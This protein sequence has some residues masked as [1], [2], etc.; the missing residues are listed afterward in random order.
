MLCAALALGC[1]DDRASPARAAPRELTLLHTSDIH[2]RVWPF[3]ARIS[4]LEAA[5]GLG[6]AGSV[7][8][9]GGFARLATLLEQERASGA[10]VWLDSGDALE[11]APVF[12]RFGG[13]PELE[14]L[15]RLG[16]SAMALGNHELS[17]AP[18]QLGDLLRS[19][20]PFPVLA[21]NLQVSATSPLAGLLGPSVVL[22]AGDVRLGVVGVAN[23]QSPPSLG[24]SGNVW[25]LTVAT[26]LAVAVQ[27]A[28]D[29][30]AP[31]AELVVL[32]SH[33]GLDTDRALVSATSGIA[34]VLGGHQHILTA[35]PEWQDDCVEDRLRARRGCSSH[36]VPIV[37]SGAYG[38]WLTRLSLTLAADRARPGQLRVEGASLTPLPLAARVAEEPRTAESLAS[39][40]PSPRA[41]LAFLPER[42]GRRSPL[43]GDSAL[44]NLTVDA[45][46]RETQADAALLNSSGLREDLEPGVL[47]LSDLELAFPF[48]EPWR[49]ARLSG[50]ELRAGL[51][52]AAFKSATR[53]CESSL[54]ISGLRIRASCSACAAHRPECL[55]VERT[56]AFGDAPLDDAEWLWVA[57]PTYLTLAGADFEDA[58]SGTELD[59]S[60]PQVLARQI[61]VGPAL[62]APEP[63]V[64]DISRW[65]QR[66]CAE[67][68]GAIACP[69]GAERAR[70]VCRSLPALKGVRDGRVEMRP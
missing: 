18:D 14:L 67:A 30:L 21:A 63:C 69:L 24:H 51:L 33:L 28:V 16:L 17:L 25:G 31:R 53:Q 66:R 15:G 46:R 7:E 58:A 57:L 60:V 5:H 42:L 55:F 19:A 65:S 12:Q 54:Q 2:S 37:H 32:L 4:E 48:E 20:A 64:A 38:Q 52:R 50:R 6:R 8:E 43:G 44:G 68:F 40:A 49:L 36:P 1:S 39:L 23:Q 10:A 70:A 41:P 11:G 61:G 13:R 56:G 26:A 29:D 62:G 27:Q 35:E 22:H 3:R 47:L 34:V 59:G 9:V 45:M